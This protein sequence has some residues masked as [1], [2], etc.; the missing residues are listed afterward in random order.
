LK[1]VKVQAKRFKH[2][3]MK[4]EYEMATQSLLPRQ[5]ANIP[6]NLQV[7]QKMTWTNIKRKGVKVAVEGGGSVI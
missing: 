3:K 7:Q 1:Q 4:N 6:K 2:T 5:S